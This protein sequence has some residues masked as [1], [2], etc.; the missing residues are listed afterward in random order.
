MEEA[1]KKNSM[2]P[3]THLQGFCLA[4]SYKYNYFI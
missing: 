3:E 2:Q 1:Q 4:A